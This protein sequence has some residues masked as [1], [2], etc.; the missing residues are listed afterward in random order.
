MGP[1]DAEPDHDIASQWQLLLQ[2]GS[3]FFVAI[4]WF[5]DGVTG[6]WSDVVTHGYWPAGQWL[7]R[8]HIAPVQGPPEEERWPGVVSV[9]ALHTALAV[10]GVVTGNTLKRCFTRPVGAAVGTVAVGLWAWVTRAWLADSYERGEWGVRVIAAHM[11]WPVGE[12][13]SAPVF[14]AIGAGSMALWLGVAMTFSAVDTRSRGIVP[15]VVARYVPLAI[16]FYLLSFCFF[17]FACVPLWNQAVRFG[18]LM[19]GVPGHQ[20]EDMRTDLSS[21]SRLASA[22]HTLTLLLGTATCSVANSLIFRRVQSARANLAV[23]CLLTGAF[24]AFIARWVAFA[25][26]AR[27]AHVVH[28]ARVFFGE[29]AVAAAT[30]GQWTTVHTLVLCSYACWFA[31]GVV[32]EQCWQGSSTNRRGSGGSPPSPGQMGASAKVLI[33]IIVAFVLPVAWVFGAFG[34]MAAVWLLWPTQSTPRSER[35]IPQTP[36]DAYT[37]VSWADATADCPRTGET[38]L[39]IG[40][41]FVG[42]RLIHRLLER[43]ETRVRAFDISRANPFAGDHRVRYYQGNVCSLNDLLHAME[44]VDTVYATFAMIRFWER[45]D[46]QAALSERVNIDGTKNV[47]LAAQRSGVKRLVQTS[48][49]NVFATPKYV[50]PV[51]DETS[52][53]VTRDVSHNHYSWTKAEAE[54][55]VLAANGEAGMYTAAVRPCSGVFG[56]NDR[57]LC[58]RFLRQRVLIMPAPRSKLDYVYVDNV[59][60]GHLKCEARLRETPERIG[61]LAFNISNDEPVT[62]ENFG[63]AIQHYHGPGLVRIAAP[64]RLFLLICHVVEFVHWATRNRVTLGADLGIA[65]PA[66]FLTGTMEFTVK[67]GPGSRSRELLNYRP[68][69]TFDE[70]IQQ[71]IH[72]WRAA[73]AKSAESLETY[74][75]RAGG[76]QRPPSVRPKAD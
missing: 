67:H 7:E 16:M 76:P 17:R 4:L 41:G 6:V 32:F 36:A 26:P 55:L 43:G 31:S 75:E 70:A 20:I 5:R 53:L 71:T 51:M 21:L 54:K 24:S 62:F 58:E 45:L 59:V 69:Y 9:A 68:A 60:L 35:R 39:V 57:T 50:Q 30:Q 15:A 12:P 14:A 40:V 37:R 8:H 47:V 74:Q 49:S 65:T 1:D 23:L 73:N 34:A 2:I 11:R 38:Y 63:I 18:V 56:P 19:G 10:L 72:D 44:G 42:A 33:V 46:F 61:G 25:L 48:T 28:F 66:T 64:V 29:E 52:K 27:V 22:T 3:C 13:G